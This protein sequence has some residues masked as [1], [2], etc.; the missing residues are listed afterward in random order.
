VTAFTSKTCEG[1][2]FSK[3]EMN[4]GKSEIDF[5]IYQMGSITDTNHDKRRNPIYIYWE[6]WPIDHRNVGGHGI[7]FHDINREPGDSI[8]AFVDGFKWFR[9]E[10]NEVIVYCKEPDDVTSEEIYVILKENIVRTII[11]KE[12]P[13]LLQ[14]NS[15]IYAN[16]NC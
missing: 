5:R 14:I 4:D 6:Q 3:I 12:I 15:R 9:G 16:S 2:I 8:I 13:L 10:L 7:E 1:R 11:N